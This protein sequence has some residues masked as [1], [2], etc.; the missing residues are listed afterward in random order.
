MDTNSD[1]S[2]FRPLY[3]L[4]LKGFGVGILAIV[5]K[6][7]VSLSVWQKTISGGSYAELENFMIFI[8]I[9]FFI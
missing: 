8:I 6:L 4:V 9:F 2:P 7:I 5:L 1:K 3:I